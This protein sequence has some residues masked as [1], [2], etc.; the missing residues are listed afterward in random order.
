MLVIF[1]GRERRVDEFRALAAP[2]G[3][4]LDAVTDLTDQRC[5]PEFR[6]AEHA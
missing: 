5:L 4:V 1:G 3:L 6:R 2:H